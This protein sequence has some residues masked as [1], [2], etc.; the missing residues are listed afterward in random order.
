MVTQGVVWM[1]DASAREKTAAVQGLGPGEEAQAASPREE[2]CPAS[3]LR[4]RGLRTDQPTWDGH[5]GCA[6]AVAS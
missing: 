1:A 3:T 4:A 2:C 5:V 6:G